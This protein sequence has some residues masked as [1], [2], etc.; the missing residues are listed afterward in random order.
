MNSSLES[1]VQYSYENILSEKLGSIFFL[2]KLRNS[3]KKTFL[4][5]RISGSLKLVRKE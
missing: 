3:H 2:R 4:C 5:I 1:W